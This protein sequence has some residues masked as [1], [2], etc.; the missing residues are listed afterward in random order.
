MDYV[1]GGLLFDLC[2]TMG[3]MGEEAGKDFL[4]QMIDVLDYM[5]NDK[6]C[7]HRDIK[8][9]NILIDSDLN[10]KLTDF[11][12]STWTN[13]DK[14]NSHHGTKTYMAPE[15]K[16]KITYSG[17]SVDIFSLA[18]CLYIVVKGQF[19]FVEAK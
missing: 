16:K 3:A 10:L 17:K 13:I 15:I 7:V 6:K 14:L 8:L 11:G 19:P 4:S 18:V 2:Q 5:H 9:E 1:E 12:F